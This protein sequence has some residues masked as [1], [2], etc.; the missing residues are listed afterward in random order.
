MKRLLAAVAAASLLVAQGC[1]YAH[2]RVPL[3]E[4]LSTTRLGAKTG[5]ASNQ[6]ILGLV[7][8]GDA[9]TQ[10]AAENGGIQTINHADLE[11]MNVLWFVY[12]RE[13]TIVYGD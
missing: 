9:G 13:T 1:V 12:S 7:A 11:I 2:I 3:D 10:A 6:Q 4:D 5:R 8:W